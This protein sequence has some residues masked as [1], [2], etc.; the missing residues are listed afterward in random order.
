M[1]GLK[2]L[3]DEYH[4]KG[5]EIYSISLDEDRDVWKKAIRDDNLPWLHVNDKDGN[6]ANQW[7]VHVIPTTFL[8]DTSGKIVAVDEDVRE[9]SKLISHLVR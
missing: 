6:I 3:Y 2:K 8:L 7:I 4:D 9:M 1:P 5:F